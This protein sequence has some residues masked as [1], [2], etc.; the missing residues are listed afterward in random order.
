MVRQYQLAES[1][2]RK[3][4]VQDSV[5]SRIG[6]ETSAKL[7]TCEKS[8]ATHF[9]MD[10]NDRLTMR[11]CG[12]RCPAAALHR[13][14]LRPRRISALSALRQPQTQRAQRYA[15]VAEIESLRHT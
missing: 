7:V 15:E 6:E 9:A 10:A 13:F 4:Q 3:P 5:P 8:V 2:A 12:V 11:V 14:T 1:P